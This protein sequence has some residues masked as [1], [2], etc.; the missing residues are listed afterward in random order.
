[1][2]FPDI[3]DV[4]GEIRWV[5]L[6]GSRPTTVYTNGFDSLRAVVGS[7]FTRPAKGVSAFSSLSDS[8][9]SAWLR[10]ENLD[11]EHSLTWAATNNITYYGPESIKLKFNVKTGLISG[12]YVDKPNGISIRIGGVFLEDQQLVTGFHMTGGES[13]R[14]VIEHRE[15]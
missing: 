13:N 8:H 1:M 7:Q 2:H 10:I 9:H 5:K 15:Q 11:L 14:I 6:S 3:S 4:D 12:S